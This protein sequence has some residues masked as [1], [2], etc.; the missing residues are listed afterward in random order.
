MYYKMQRWKLTC[1]NPFAKKLNGLR[2]LFYEK[3]GCSE[4]NVMEIAVKNDLYEKTIRISS[5]LM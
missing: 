5:L 4:V 1:Y 3:I 2:N